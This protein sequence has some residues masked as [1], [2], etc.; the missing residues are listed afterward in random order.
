MTAR[1]LIKY[2]FFDCQLKTRKI[3][4]KETNLELKCFYMDYY[5]LHV[6]CVCFDQ[7]TLSSQIRAYY[8]CLIHISGALYVLY[9]GLF[10]IR[11]ILFVPAMFIMKRNTESLRR[12]IYVI[13]P[14]HVT[15]TD[16][17]KTITAPEIKQTQES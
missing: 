15:H 13:M 16:S 12:E 10:L 9:P 11:A 1:N 17:T 3:I 2:L 14:D 4:N 7:F 6:K 8:E 5:Q